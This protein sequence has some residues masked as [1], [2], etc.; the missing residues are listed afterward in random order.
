MRQIKKTCLVLH[1]TLIVSPSHSFG[2]ILPAFQPTLRTH[3]TLGYMVQRC[4]HVHWDFCTVSKRLLY[5]VQPNCGAL[6]HLSPISGYP[7]WHHGHFHFFPQACKK[8]NL[9]LPW[10]IPK[11]FCLMFPNASCWLPISSADSQWSTVFCWSS[12]I[13]SYNNTAFYTLYNN[14]VIHT[15]QQHCHSDIKQ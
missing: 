6:W 7:L 12:V 8:W 3:S 1:V 2:H 11:A 9:F 13:S 15:L 10:R 4:L 5:G 14:T